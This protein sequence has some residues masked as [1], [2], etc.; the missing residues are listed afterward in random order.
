MCSVSVRVCVRLQ[1]RGWVGGCEGG[2]GASTFGRAERA[3]SWTWREGRGASVWK[4]SVLETCS[5]DHM[6]SPRRISTESSSFCKYAKSLPPLSEDGTLLS[7]GVS[8]GLP[9]LSVE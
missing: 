9:G 4:S 7:P 1:K 5:Q 2:I 8:E 3:V 6:S